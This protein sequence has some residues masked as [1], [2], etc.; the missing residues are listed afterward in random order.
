ML[1]KPY[2]LGGRGRANEGV[3]C[4]GLIFRAMEAA[5]RCG[6]QSFSVL[7]VNNVRDHELGEPVPELSPVASASLDL[8]KLQPGDVIWLVAPDQN[9]AEA[10]IGKLD[11]RDVWVWHTG[12]YAGDGRWIVGDHF[13]Q[14]VV[15]TD[16]REY[17][18]AHAQT[19]S[20]VFVLRIDKA[21]APKRC[22]A[23]RKKDV[24][25]PRINSR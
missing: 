8:S 25:V 12:L 22:R 19:Y 1:G 24:L 21:P 13:A 5:M 16:L 2:Q 4:Q 15:E 14:E 3:D 7:N 17:L 23:P 20:G 9:P 11:G 10:A 6:Y 18:T